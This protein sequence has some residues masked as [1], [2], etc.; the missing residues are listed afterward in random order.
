MV[1]DDE[2]E[3]VRSLRRIFRKKYEVLM[4]ESAEEARLMMGE[5]PAQVVISDQ[6]MPGTTGTELFHY[7][8]KSHPR[9]IRILLTGYS[10]IE[11]VISAVNE[12]DVFHYVAK[13]WEPAELETIVQ[14]AFEHYRLVQQNQSLVAELQQANE[15]LEQR[16]SERTADLLTANKALQ[17]EI[18][19]RTK[20]EADLRRAKEAADLATKAKSHFLATMSH[21]IRTPMNAVIGFT[22]MLMDTRLEDEQFEYAETIKKSGESLLSLINDILD[23]SKVEAGEMELDHIEFDPELLAYDVCDMIRPR[24]LSSSVEILCRIGNSLP[25]RLRGDPGRLR[26]VLMNLMGNASKFTKQGEI[27]LSLDVAKEENR[28]LTLHVVVRDTGIGI[29]PEQAKVIFEPFKQADSST[30]RRF[31]GTGLG[32]AICK[33]IARL[34]GGDIWVESEDGNGS[35]FHFTAKLE[36]AEPAK[37]L[38]FQSVSLAGKKALIVDD[39]QRNLDILEYVLGLGKIG[40]TALDHST[41]VIET[42]KQGIQNGI[43]YD[44]CII[45]IQM[46][47]IS[48]YDVAQAIRREKEFR[49]LPL[50]ALS[51]I[52]QRDARRCESAGFDGFLSKPLRRRKLFQM[53]RRLFG[54]K[55]AESG[56]EREQAQPIMTQYSV[57]EDAKHSTRILLAEDNVVNQKLARLMLEKAGYLVTVVENGKDALESISKSPD[58]FDLILMDVMMPE[59]DGLTA[60]RRIRALED[61]RR[62]TEDSGPSSAVRRPSSGIPIIAMTAG[63]MEGD[64]ARCM[65]AGMND[66]ISKPVKREVV[67]EMLEK[68]VFEKANET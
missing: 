16:V 32:L 56:R 60:T 67:Y 8:K 30:T 54:Q 34:L 50:I 29:S 65:E 5:K 63:A 13:P 7:L 4:A 58:G 40:V 11:A 18:D 42:L 66:Y 12:G 25:S 21:E 9:T 47:E 2:R 23:F 27:E 20:V 1:V 68:W 19:R 45:D 3:V 15:T 6:R 59:M 51:S 64:R 38:H 39:N 46:P 48:G 53:L 61:G 10:D 41:G 22:D 24:L 43:P 36:V 55:T 14:Q 33:Q 35:R 28:L 44:F 17:S 37:P 26:Q 52:M 49:D 57:R 62:K 31:G